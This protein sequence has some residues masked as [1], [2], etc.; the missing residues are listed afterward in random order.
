MF[1]LRMFQRLKIRTDSTR[2]ISVLPKVIQLGAADAFVSFVTIVTLLN[3]Y[4]PQS[5]SCPIYYKII[6]IIF[7]SFSFVQKNP[8][9]YYV[10]ERKTKKPLHTEV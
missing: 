7:V 4:M 6:T 10:S 8:R 9:V 3:Q 1:S 5:I 2:P